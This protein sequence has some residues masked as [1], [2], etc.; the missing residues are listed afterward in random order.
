MKLE[1]DDPVMGEVTRHY[2]LHVP[3]HFNRSNT[4]GTPL[5]LDYHGWG[6][7]AQSHLL[8]GHNFIKVAEEDIHGGFLVATG[9]G[10]GDG[11]S[12]KIWGSWNC[13]AT[14]GP[15][16]PVCVLPRGVDYEETHCYKSCSGCHPQNSCDWTSCFDDVLY[17]NAIIEQVSSL[18]CIDLDSIHQ[19]GMSN[20]AMFSYFLASRTDQL[21]SI[22]PVS[23]SPLIGFGQPPSKPIS[24]IDFHGLEDRVIPYDITSAKGEGPHGSVIDERDGY[25]YHPKPNLILTWASAFGCGPGQPWKTEMDGVNSWSCI[26]FPHCRAGAEVVSCTGNYGHNYPFGNGNWTSEMFIEA[27]RMMWSFMKK[28][29]KQG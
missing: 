18:F 19:T 14:F 21:A 2:Q 12:S 5:L 28:H 26:I 27:S 25:Y 8:D 20:G 23:G 13:S 3:H 6:S 24:V 10:I 15:L 22:G 9:E 16:G 4:V 7:T 29:P 17:T 1:I 11:T